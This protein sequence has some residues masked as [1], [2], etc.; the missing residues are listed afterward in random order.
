MMKIKLILALLALAT[1]TPVAKAGVK[2]IGVVNGVHLVRVRTASIF[3]PSSTVILSYVPGTPGVEVVSQ[4][5]GAGVVPSVATAGG[6][7]GGAALLRPARS[8]DSANA[9][10]SGGGGGA[11]DQKSTRLN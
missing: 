6:I 8:S 2:E 9:G 7:V 10:A 1:V 3:A 5:G 4:V 11:G